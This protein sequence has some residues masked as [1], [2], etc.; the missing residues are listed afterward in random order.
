ML[1]TTTRRKRY[2]AVL[3]TVFALN[4][5]VVYLSLT[6]GIFEITVGD[7]LKT[8]LRLEVVPQYDLLLF[9]F[10]LPRIVAAGVV[11]AALGVAGVVTQGITR[12]GLADPGVLGINAGAGLGIVGY[13]ALVQGKI[14]TAGWPGGLIM[15][16]FGLLGGLGAALLIFLCSWQNGK[17]DPERLV[18]TGIAIGSGLGAAS[19]YLTLKMSPGD[20]QL[21]TVWLAG[22][23][24]NA[25]WRQ[26]L[27][28]LPW[29]AGLLPVIFK[30]SVLLDLFQLEESSVR[31]LGVATEGE[32]AIL[33]LS[34]VGLVSVCVA[35]AGGI[36][37]VGLIVPH[38][39]KALAG[40]GH[41]RTIPLCAGL[42]MAL[43]MG[44]D[45]IGRILFA[46][47]ELAVGVVVTL[48]GAPYFIYLLFTAKAYTN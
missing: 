16:L 33:L 31:S 45:F 19:L 3:L 2:W 6:H 1:N 44:A 39:A 11:G 35:V 41:H 47:A 20:F 24:A 48:I 37:F 38:L 28:I 43:V 26:I 25:D 36:G 5:A 17:L 22:S 40:Y 9:E 42:G 21:A 32:K 18:L 4:L 34:G 46:P 27:L 10:R 23:V 7:V 12:N 15:P 30:K 14:I 13:M 8:L 29:L